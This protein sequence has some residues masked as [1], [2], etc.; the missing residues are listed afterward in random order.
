METDL[1]RL[2]QATL[3]I[4]LEK[5][6]LSMPYPYIDQV[7]CFHDSEEISFLETADCNLVTEVHVNTLTEL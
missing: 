3:W 7:C 1:F 5:L 4:N 6:G 2:Q